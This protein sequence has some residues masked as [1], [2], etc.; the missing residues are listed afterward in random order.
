VT[1]LRKDWNKIFPVVVMLAM[2]GFLP[3]KNVFAVPP[4]KTVAWEGGGAGRVV[5]EGTLHKNKGLKC[6]D[7]HTRLFANMKSGS[8]R[9][10]MSMK[11]MYEGNFCGACHNGKEAFSLNDKANCAK[12]HKK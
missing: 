3:C 12:C 1:G 10:R 11:E 8:P 5:F 9:T 6:H 7:C 2:M 4:G